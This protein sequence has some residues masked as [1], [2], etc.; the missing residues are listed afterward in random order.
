MCTFLGMWNSCLL[1]EVLAFSRKICVVLC[2]SSFS[3]YAFRAGPLWCFD[4]WPSAVSWFSLC[5]GSYLLWLPL[6]A[7]QLSYGV[8][9]RC[10]CVSLRLSISF[11]ELDRESYYVL[12][13]VDIG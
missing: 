5:R 10:G 2:P 13:E 9:V 3:C 1:F 12:V 6:Q 8:G 7:M 4:V 11:S